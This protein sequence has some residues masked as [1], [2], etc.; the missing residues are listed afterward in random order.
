M[1]S[2][3]KIK[4]PDGM[5]D[6]FRVAVQERFGSV[7]GGCGVGLEAACRWLATTDNLG[8]TVDQAKQLVARMPYYGKDYLQELVRWIASEWLK[9]MFLAPEPEVPEEVRDLLV[10][11]VSPESY[12]NPQ[13]VEAFRRGQKS[14]Q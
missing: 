4:V 14:K 9:E 11:A 10:N 13:I 6:A 12:P 7:P 1:T 2:S 8:P 5:M 3:I